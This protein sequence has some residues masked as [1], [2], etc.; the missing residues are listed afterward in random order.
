MDPTRINSC[1]VAL[2][3]WQ[4]HRGFETSIGKGVNMPKKPSRGMYT[5]SGYSGMKGSVYVLF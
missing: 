4:Y 2:V 5:V 3:M 1:H